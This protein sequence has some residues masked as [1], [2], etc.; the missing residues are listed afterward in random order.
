MSDGTSIEWTRGLD[1]RS[2]ATWNP[3]TGCWELSP[4]CDNCYAKRFAERFRGVPG[5]PFEHGFDL[6]VRPDRLTEPFHWR[7]PRLVFVNSMSDLFHKDI[8]DEYIANVFAVMAATPQHIYQLLTKRHGRMRS[9]LSSPEFAAEVFRAGRMGGSGWSSDRTFVADTAEQ[10][11]ENNWP[12]RNLWLGV[13]VEN[14]RWADIRIPALLDTPAAVHWLSCEPLLGPVSIS[15][16]LDQHGPW[17]YMQGGVLCACGAPVDRNERCTGDQIDWVVVGGES[18]PGARPM[19]PQWARRLRDECTE[20]RTPYF[21]KQ[22]GAWGPAPWV[23]RVCD[24]KVGWQGTSEEL[25]A[26]KRAA[27]AAGATHTY[28]AWA[29]QHDWFTIEAEH[30]PWSLERQELS[31]DNHA[32]IRRWGKHRAGRELDG[33]TW[34]QYP[35]VAAVAP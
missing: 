11:A 3:V 10:W 7:R 19:H 33:R 34:D 20:Y 32:P 8:P 12:L 24:P 18:G 27:E 9:L 31:G 29:D 4:G 25:T 26:A 1:G 6:Q 22:W 17:H 13:S 15:R 21:F 23:V 2:G 14:Q 5:H 35:S 16:W 30:K 28:A